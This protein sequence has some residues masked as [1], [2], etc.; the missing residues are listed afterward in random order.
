MKLKMERSTRGSVLIL[1]LWS[2]GF[3]AWSLLSLVSQFQMRLPE[4]KRERD[5]C[6]G[7]LN[8]VSGMNYE[9]F[10]LARD[11][12]PY[13]DDPDE[14]LRGEVDLPEEWRGVFSLRVE[15]E[16]SKINLNAAGE[17]L[18]VELVKT[19][20]DAGICFETEGKEL[21]KKIIEAREKKKSRQFEF[22]E[23]LL[24]IED[25]PE[26]DLLALKTY[27]TVS[28]AVSVFPSVNVNTAQEP[29]LKALLASLPG[30]EFR[31]NELLSKILEQRQRPEKEKPFFVKE[32]LDPKL[33]ISKLELTPTA[34]ML[35]LVNVLVPYLLTDS[36][37]FRLEIAAP[38]ENKRAEALIRPRPEGGAPLVLWWNED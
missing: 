16:E 36:Q 17:K 1:S 5:A 37:T 27:V 21:S 38:K 19:L 10:L 15:D 30:D 7:H 13:N 3:L 14:S 20:G 4:A 11:E 6:L 35:S 22:L 29:V 2:A 12:D 24:R 31:K 28:S 23:D 9:A 26:A 34:E 32:E 33:F 25:L 8:L 18:L